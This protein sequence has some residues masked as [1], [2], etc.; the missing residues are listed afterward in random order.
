MYFDQ[1]NLESRDYPISRVGRDA[2]VEYI[3]RPGL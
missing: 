2:W 1:I 3:R